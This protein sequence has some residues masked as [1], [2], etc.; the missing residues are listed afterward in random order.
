M[1]AFIALDLIACLD[2]S[3][4]GTCFPLPVADSTQA[5]PDGSQVIMTGCMETEEMNPRK[6]FW[7]EHQDIRNVY[8]SG[9]SSCQIASKHAPGRSNAWRQ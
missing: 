6:R 2:P 1:H 7:L 9:G 3:N 5:Q 8:H 4:F